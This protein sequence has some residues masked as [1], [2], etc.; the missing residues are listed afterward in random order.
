MVVCLVLFFLISEKN[1]SKDS[2]E[3]MVENFFHKEREQHSRNT[4][5]EWK[6][7]WCEMKYIK[8][9]NLQWA[10]VFYGYQQCCIFF[11]YIYDQ[12]RIMKKQLRDISLNCHVVFYCMFWNDGNSAAKYLNKCI[13]VCN[14]HLHFEYNLNLD[15]HLWPMVGF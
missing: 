1:K 8:S 14:K 5:V 9:V 6:F 11:W 10:R 15:F 13:V 7:I 12:F 4:V 2:R 3:N